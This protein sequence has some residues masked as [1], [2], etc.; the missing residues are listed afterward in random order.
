[1]TAAV[2]RCATATDHDL[3]DAYIVFCRELELSDRALRD[4]LRAARSF[5][6]THPDLDGWM[7]RPV[8]ARVTDLRR[9]QAWPL[10][11]WAILSGRVTADLELCWSK[12]SG[13]WA[14]PPSS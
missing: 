1:M 3:L 2:A 10:I 11:G 12:T 4:R 5:L 14:R 7:R 6:A 9:T 8:P 13:R